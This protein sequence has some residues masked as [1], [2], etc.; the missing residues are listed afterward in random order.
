MDKHEDISTLNDPD[1]EELTAYLDGELDADARAAVERR[2]SDDESFR[3]RMQ[4]ME[5]AWAMLDALPRTEADMSFAQSTVEMVALAAKEDLQ[6]A[7]DSNR[8]RRWIGWTATVAAVALA[9]FL[10]FRLVD[11]VTSAENDQLVRDLPVIEN[12]E[13][14]RHVDDIEFLRQLE[15]EGLFDE[16]VEGEVLDSEGD[17]NAI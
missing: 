17:G 9:A 11:R 12:V 15:A 14:Y 8:R 4:R 5:D 10:G 6:A 13:L 16:A 1:H 7:S 3:V 2:L